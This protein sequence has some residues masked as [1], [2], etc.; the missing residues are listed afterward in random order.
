[1]GPNEA[2]QRRRASGGCCAPPSL[3]LLRPLP[4]QSPNILEALGA[5]AA[6]GCARRSARRPH[7][8]AAI[9]SPRRGARRG[10]ADG[11]A[12]RLRL[13]PPPPA[14]RAHPR[15]LPAPRGDAG[16]PAAAPTAVSCSPL[17]ALPSGISPS[18]SL[19]EREDK[20][21]PRP[22]PRLELEKPSPPAASWVSSHI[23]PPPASPPAGTHHA[24]PLNSESR[25]D[26]VKG[27][28]WGALQRPYVFIQDPTCLSR[29]HVCPEGLRVPQRCSYFCRNKQRPLTHPL[30]P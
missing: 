19:R 3:A 10:A 18:R 6:G 27:W 11:R 14:A 29:T 4:P 25:V 8:G 7:C 5:A 13:L 26:R 22:P 23:Q 2:S 28:I 30:E 17:A 1:M 16:R 12:A 24:F 15:W 9:N 21:L 20:F